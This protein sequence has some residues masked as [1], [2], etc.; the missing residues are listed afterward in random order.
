MFNINFLFKNTFFDENNFKL[1]FAFKSL[2]NLAILRR[3]ILKTLKP[4][5]S[6]LEFLRKCS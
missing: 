4:A 2:D 3:N 1:F 5:V 6:L